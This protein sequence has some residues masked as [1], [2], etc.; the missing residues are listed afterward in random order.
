M[1]KVKYTKIMLFS[2]FLIG[3]S[4][5]SDSEKKQD[6]NKNKADNKK[7]NKSNKSTFKGKNTSYEIVTGTYNQDSCMF[8]P[9]GWVLKSDP[10]KIISGGIYMLDPQTGVKW[11]EK[12]IEPG[13]KEVSKGNDGYERYFYEN[14]KKRSETVISD[15]GKNKVHTSWTKEGIKKFETTTLIGDTIT[16]QIQKRFNAGDPSKKDGSLSTQDFS[17]VIGSGINGIQKDSLYI[18]AEDYI[19][20]KKYY[21]NGLLQ[22][23]SYWYDKEGKQIGKVLFNQNRMVKAKGTYSFGLY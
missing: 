11:L 3:A 4:S 12:S 18:Y 13:K 19:A 7:E 16:K 9:D 22:G 23:Y 10:S 20:V 1:S 21:K 2:L 14:G 6:S 5:C 8:Y 15:N 17:T